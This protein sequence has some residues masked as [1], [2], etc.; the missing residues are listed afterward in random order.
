VVVL[1]VAGIC[2]GVICVIVG[3]LLRQSGGPM[4]TLCNSAY[5]AYGQ[6]TSSVVSSGCTSASAKVDGGLALIIAGVTLAIGGLVLFFKRSGPPVGL[7]G[8]TTAPPGS[9]LGLSV[10]PARGAS[11]GLESG[12]H[13][14]SVANGSAAAMAGIKRGMWLC[15]V[16]EAPIG[17]DE[18]LR[19]AWAAATDGSR[20]AVFR[21]ADGKELR[22]APAQTAAANGWDVAADA[23]A[24]GNTNAST[25]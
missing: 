7:E 4:N 6:V 12:V 21:F 11:G 20:S 22:V 14:T 8:L 25:S 17:N 18:D 24:G 19:L 23:L 13:I 5:G 10:R 3:A 2:L 15:F 9:A 1:G 16:D